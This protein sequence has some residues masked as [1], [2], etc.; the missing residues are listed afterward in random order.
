MKL[1]NEAKA[2]ELS[3]TETLE[4]SPD[5]IDSEQAID[6]MVMWM[7]RS[8][9]MK[10]EIEPDKQS[11][12]P[13]YDSLHA[14]LASKCERIQELEQEARRL[15][16]QRDQESGRLLDLSNA[17]TI[18][19]ERFATAEAAIASL[20]VD[21]GGA[22][23]QAHEDATWVCLDRQHFDRLVAA[24]AESN[25]LQAEI[26]TLKGSRFS[27]DALMFRLGKFEERTF[28]LMG[29]LD[30]STDGQPIENRFSVI[31]EAVKRNL[32][33]LD[34]NKKRIAMLW[35]LLSKFGYRELR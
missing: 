16:H 6:L 18:L 27:T 22:K 32:A 5:E 29:V 4:F 9:H 26:A 12:D 15:T 20:E 25:S 33:A 2:G 8:S 13:V 31:I 35:E 21:L 7:D 3:R 11:S 19:Q 24:E 23:M 17:Y 14:D 10:H 34:G 30:I 28:E 1:S